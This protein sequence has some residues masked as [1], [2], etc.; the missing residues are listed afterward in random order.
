[1]MARPVVV[2]LAT[3]LVFALA[4]CWRE[5]TFEGAI[6]VALDPALFDRDGRHPTLEVDLVGV[7]NEDLARWQAMPILTYFEP[8]NQLRSGSNRHTLHFPPDEAGPRR[9]E[10]EDEIWQAWKSAGAES[11][12]ILVNLPPA[13][14]PL[15]PGAPD[16][17]RLV[18]SLD[19]EAMPQAAS[20]LV[21]LRITPTGITPVT[22]A[23]GA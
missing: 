21:R 3:V 19:A 22:P 14:A 5:R 8:G 20:R 18:V 23:P 12:V 9:L 7:R 6:V 1:M 15:P 4:G 17:R 11:L 10:R 16:P 2:L 13:L